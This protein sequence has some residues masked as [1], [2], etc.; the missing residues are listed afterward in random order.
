MPLQCVFVQKWKIN[1]MNRNIFKDL[2][3]EKD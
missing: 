3:T 1:N 2:K